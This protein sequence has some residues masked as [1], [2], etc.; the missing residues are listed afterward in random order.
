MNFKNP[1]I[2]LTHA[3]QINQILRQGSLILSSI[4]LAK[5]ALDVQT[6]GIYETLNFVG[7]TLSFFWLNALIQGTLANP[8]SDKKSIE[9]FNIFLIFNTLCIIFFVIMYFFQKPILL[10]LTQNQALPY[11]NL[12]AFFLL[13]NL[14]PLFLEGFWIREAAPL[15]IL[16]Y[17]I[18]SHLLQPLFLIVPIFVSNSLEWGIIGL[19]LTGFLRY[20]W[21]IINVLKH[22]TWQ[23]DIAFIQRF[24]VLCMPLAAYSL[25]N[26]FSTTFTHWYI[27]WHFSEADF[28][29]FRFGA[30]E[31]PLTL[32]LTMA[33]S[34]AFVPQLCSEKNI[35]DSKALAILKQQTTKLWHILFPATI[36]LL[37]LAKFLFPLVF[38]THFGASA[39]IFC[40]F[41]LLL[42]PRAVFPQTLLLA[43]GDTKNILFISIIETFSIVLASVLLMPFWGM[44][45][46][47]WAIFIGFCIEKILIIFLLKKKYNIDFHSFTNI[48]IYTWY[49]ITLIFVYILQAGW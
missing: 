30:R 1:N 12:Y 9:Y 46:V 33:L 49:V 24:L 29:I 45:G 10:F 3:L 2:S 23:I 35:I 42:I 36:A 5:T 25:L 21:L 47:A 11:F 7:T 27:K 19:V 8:K 38:N 44:Q 31:F 26:S 43:L 6:I 16:R 14:P 48:K 32:A 28:A 18:V 17:A 39:P 37:L 15:S 34:N 22:T 41:L 4:L 13:L 40:I 20:I